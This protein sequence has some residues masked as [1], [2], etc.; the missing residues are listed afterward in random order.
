[1]LLGASGLANIE[2]FHNFAFPIKTLMTLETA[3]NLSMVYYMFLVGLETDFSL[4]LRAGKQA[5]SVALAGFVF[6]MPAGYGLFYKLQPHSKKRGGDIFWAVALACTNFPDLA[7]ILADVKLLRSDFGRTAL[8]SALISDLC[9]WVLMVLSM[10]VL[11]KGKYISLASTTVFILICVFAVRPALKWIISHRAKEEDYNEFHVCLALTGAILFGFIS[12]ACG[13]HSIA[14][15]FMLGVVMPKGELK[16]TI[17]EKVEEYVS[18]VMMPLFYLVIGLRVNVAQMA[19][20][21]SWPNVCLVI[22]LAFVP[23]IVSTFF[24]SLL[25]KMPALDSLALGLL[26]NTKG[27][28]SIIILSSGRDLKVLL[29]VLFVCVCVIESADV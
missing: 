17:M 2:F 19:Y 28:L 23:K 26:M 15:A 8:T 18:G 5:Y 10:A 6:A 7:R 11:H 29:Y 24:V 20:N 13:A 22:A 4:I 12:D 9:C 25:Y 27:M 16:E 1:M 14:G 21:T 3:A